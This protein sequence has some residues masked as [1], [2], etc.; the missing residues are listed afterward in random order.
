MHKLLIIGASGGI[1]RRTVERALADGHAVRAVARRASAIDIDDP[2]LEKCDIDATDAEALRP[3]LDGVSV[4]IQA[5]GVAPSLARTL[6]P[7]DLFS[8]STA[9]LLPEMARAGLRRL[10]SVTGFGAGDSRT[11]MSFLERTGHRALL[12]RAYDDKDTQEAMI[13]ESDLDWLIVRPTILT[14]RPARGAYKVLL[15]PAEWRNGLIARADVADFLVRE[16]V[17]PR[18]SRTTPVLTN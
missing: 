5:I 3:A 2:Q 16:A 13:R 11:A 14:N 18:H 6:R 15:D 12:G 17:T 10:V 4:V 9:A 1:G 7:V 8:K